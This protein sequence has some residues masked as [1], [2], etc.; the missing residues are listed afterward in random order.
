[1]ALSKVGQILHRIIARCDGLKQ[2]N[3]HGLRHTCCSLMT[4]SGATPHQIKAVLG[5]SNTKMLEI[6]THVATNEKTKATQNYADYLS[7]SALG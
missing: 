4:E 5:H 3:V 1:M 2:I 7:N 6:Y